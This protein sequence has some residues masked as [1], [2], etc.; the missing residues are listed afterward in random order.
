MLI[1]KLFFKIAKFAVAELAPNPELQA[2]TVSFAKERIVLEA[3]AQWKN[4]KPKLEQVRDTAICAA[5]NVADGVRANDPKDF[6][7]NFYLKR[8]NDCVIE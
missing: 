8:P 2:K 1:Y 5:K 4:T 3:K 7:K 6:R